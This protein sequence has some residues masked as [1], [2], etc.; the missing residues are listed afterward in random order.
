MAVYSHLGLGRVG[1][2]GDSLILP[3]NSLFY[4][5]D[6]LSWVLTMPKHSPGPGSRLEISLIYIV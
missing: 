1:A 2:G 6:P 5:I 3:W 4:L